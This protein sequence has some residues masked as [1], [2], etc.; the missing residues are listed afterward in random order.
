MCALSA[1]PFL[2]IRTGMQTPRWAPGA[3]TGPL[4][5]TLHQLATGSDSSQ[6]Q[7]DNAVNVVFL[8]SDL[9]GLGVSGVFN[10]KISSNDVK[11]II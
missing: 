4:K 11:A 6:Y 8:P 2:K 5:G 9:S 10:E 3:S 7:Q 1:P